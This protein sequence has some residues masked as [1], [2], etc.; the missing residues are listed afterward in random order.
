MV[1]HFI[2]INCVY[3]LKKEKNAEMC[4]IFWPFSEHA[5]NISIYNLIERLPCRYWCKGFMVRSFLFS[6]DPLLF[7]DG[8]K[9]T[10]NEPEKSA[11]NI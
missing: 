9:L 3:I 7:C 8:N 6:C 4:C 2:L 5:K 1:E 11:V 10:E